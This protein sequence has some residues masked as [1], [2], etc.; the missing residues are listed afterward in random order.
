MDPEMKRMGVDPGK[1]TGVSRR[2][3]HLGFGLLG[4]VV[5][6]GMEGWRWIQR[7]RDWGLT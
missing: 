2:H 1:G 3:N 7:W 5:D 4:T 6:P